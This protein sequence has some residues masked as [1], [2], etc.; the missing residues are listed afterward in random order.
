[1]SPEERK[2]FEEMSR[3]LEELTTFMNDEK[4]KQNTSLVDDAARKLTGIG[5]IGRTAETVAAGSIL[6]QSNEGPIKLLYAA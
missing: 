5:F 1:M 4:E 3:K 2:Q 6:V